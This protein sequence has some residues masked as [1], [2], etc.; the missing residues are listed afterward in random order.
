MS[1]GDKLR[2]NSTFYHS[3]EGKAQ[4]KEDRNKRKEAKEQ[5][6]RKICEKYYKNNIKPL[7]IEA[8]LSGQNNICFNPADDVYK[9][10][11]CKKR[12]RKF[13][14]EFLK[15][16]GLTFEYTCDPFTGGSVT[17]SW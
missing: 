10:V 3:K 11:F 14:S 16:E 12:Y 17:I 15:D 9:D 2:K 5:N 6:T 13:F 7:L 8:S 1:F 4:R